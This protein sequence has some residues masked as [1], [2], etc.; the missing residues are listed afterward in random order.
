MKEGGEREKR[1]EGGRAWREGGRAWDGIVECEFEEAL[2]E[3]K[4]GRKG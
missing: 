1:G 2:N 4:G 3:G